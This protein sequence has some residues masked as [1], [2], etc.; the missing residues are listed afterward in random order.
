MFSRENA[1]SL[2]S[3]A[4]GLKRTNRALFR[5]QNKS[6]FPFLSVTVKMFSPFRVAVSWFLCVRACVRT[7]LLPRL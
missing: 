2:K 5:G 6:H 1:T 7:V 4:R 3:L